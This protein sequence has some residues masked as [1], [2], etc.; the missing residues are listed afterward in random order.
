MS[1][2]PVA[3]PQR[4]P[5]PPIKFKAL[6]QALE[7]RI[8]QLVPLWLPGGKRE[9]NE[10][11]V[12]S[13][14]R[15]EKTPSLSVCMAG[16]KLGMWQDHG[17]DKK[18]GDLVSLFA[19]VQGISSAQA[20]IELA[21]QYGLEDVAGIVHREAASTAPGPPP[22]P[23]PPPLP[24]SDRKRSDESWTPM[25]PVP[26]IAP[27]ASFKHHARKPDTIQHVAEYRVGDDLY[28]YVVRFLKS[29]GGKETLPHVW[30]KSERDGSMK[31]CWKT[32][33]K[34]R[35]LYFPN[36]LLPG[37]SKT[38]I[39]VEGEVK[40]DSLQQLLD[41][42]AREVYAVCSWAGGCKAWSY[43][44]W[45]WLANCDVLLWPDCDGKREKLTKAEADA[46]ADDMARAVMEQSKPLLPAH[47]QVGMK[48]MLGIGAHLRDTHG[49][50]VQL[51]AIPEPGTVADGW[52]AADAIKVDGWDFD[53]VLGFLGTAYALP[54]DV[55][56]PPVTTGGKGNEPPRDRPVETV[57]GDD[58]FSAYLAYICAQLKCEVHELGVNRTM[59]IKALRTAPLLRDCLGYNELT[60]GPST[61]VAWPW[62]SVSGPLLDGDDLQLGDWLHA[63]Y[64]LR[65]ASR[66]ALQEAI[67]TVAHARRY[68]PVRD[69]LKGLKHDGKSRIDK[70]LIHILDKDLPLANKP[71]I[72]KYMEL[73]G[74]YILMGLVA[75]VMEPGCK[76]D[77]APVLEGPGGIGKSTFVKTLVG[78]EFFSDTHFEIGQ[79]NAGMEQFAGL[80]AYELSELTA[81]R[82]ADSE[83]IK[84]FFSSQD[85][86]F[87]GAYGRYVQK[88]PRQLVIFCSTNKRQ[89]LFDMTGNRRFW[90][91]YVSKPIN[92][93]WLAKYREQLFAEA[94][95]LY[96]SGARY[97]PSRE[98]EEQFFVPQQERR[99][100]ETSVQS[101]LFELLARDG[102]AGEE[103][104]ASNELCNLTTFVT[105]AKL[106]I[107][108]GTDPG[109]SSTLLEAQIRAWLEAKGWMWKR[110]ST[111]LRRWGFKQ[112]DVW[113]PKIDEEE[114]EDDDTPPAPADDQRGNDDDP[115]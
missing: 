39:I 87:R 65:A 51:L 83:Q 105:V 106:V 16:K 86:R 59:I 85:D 7:G 53:R 75:R 80:W 89:Y 27:Q 49:C 90:P 20:A 14:W 81:L 10:Y 92:L 12:H 37:E 98:E 102:A 54:A 101:R 113:P 84:Q 71:K 8:E 43:A 112:P 31:W 6:A 99:L 40:A 63:H 82:R 57:D 47:E 73:V 5:L 36:H 38:V 60:D 35:P 58:E 109:K 28:G 32:W 55:S 108:L 41:S 66:A 22:P 62:R 4:D 46:C 79:G 69:W 61:Q 9:G 72:R 15:S 91:F 95:A 74:R 103:G 76:F 45:D 68:H 67:D 93:T 2:P 17:G 25:V 78:A 44:T 100:V 96:K 64:K 77:Y 3:G 110:E 1:H 56:A 94:F 107:A 24:P 70:W 19:A 97:Y 29:D 48:A 21:H 50:N 104:K 115:F 30:C 18:G 33:D 34:P 42:K 88:H 11:F 52:D 26:T 111:G 23:A 13:V 114:E